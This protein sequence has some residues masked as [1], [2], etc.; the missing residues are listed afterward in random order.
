M[1]LNHNNRNASPPSS[2]S[3]RSNDRS[4]SEEKSTPPRQG[5][6]HQAR[7]IEIPVQHIK[8]TPSSSTTTTNNIPHNIPPP[9][10]HHHPHHNRHPHQHHHSPGNSRLFRETSP[11]GPGVSTRLGA[12]DDPFNSVQPPPPGFMADS[13][14]FDQFDKNFGTLNQPTIISIHVYTY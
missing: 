8:T 1:N 10:H 9:P 3:R 2:S 7:V 14:F 6:Y 11:F 12:S 4:G 5:Q 13:D